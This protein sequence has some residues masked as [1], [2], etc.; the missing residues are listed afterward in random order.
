M[1]LNVMLTHWLMQVPMKPSPVVQ[2]DTAIGGSGR[3]S[4][5]THR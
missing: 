4:S 1:P 2:V 3:Y 5:G